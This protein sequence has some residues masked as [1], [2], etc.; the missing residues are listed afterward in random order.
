MRLGRPNGHRTTKQ[1]PTALYG[2]LR[3]ILVCQRASH[4]GR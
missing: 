1:A 2:P 4:P 3:G